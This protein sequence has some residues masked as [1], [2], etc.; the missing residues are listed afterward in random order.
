MK[1]LLLAA[2]TL[3]GR[4]ARSSHELADWSS[5]EDKRLFATLSKSAGVVIMGRNTYETMPSPLPGRFN[6]VLTSGT[7]PAGAP[8]GV[9][10]W[11]GSPQDVVEKLARR[12]YTSA[13]L[14]GGARTYREFLDA[15]LVSELW[16]TLE[17]LAFGG[18]ISL[19]GDAP[20]QARFQLIECQRLGASAVHLRYGLQS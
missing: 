18:G 9:E 15:G 6:V 8:D 2:V 20:L 1:V 14:A 4:I 12:G 7:P 17:P 19:F 5:H 11:S 13:V 16:L 3:D 10:F